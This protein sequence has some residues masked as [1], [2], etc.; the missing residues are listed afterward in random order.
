MIKIEG[1]K[2]DMI[3]KV[4]FC[5]PD[6]AKKILSSFFASDIKRKKTTEIRLRANMPASV[7]CGD[8]NIFDFGGNK[9]VF[10]EREISDIVSKLCE[11]SVHTYGNTVNEGYIA[12]PEGLRIGV[13]GRGISENSRLLSVREITS[14]CIRIPHIIK[15]AATEILPVIFQKRKIN[16]ALIFSLPGVGKT[17]I[18]RDIAARLSCAAKRRIAVVDSRGEIYIRE[19]FSN[20]ICDFLEGY[21]KGAG[22]EIATRTLSA[23]ALV[24]DEIGDGETEAILKAQ[25]TGVPLIATSHGDSFPSVIMRPGMKKLYDAGVFRY[26]IGV[27]RVPGTER[28]YFDIHDS[29]RAL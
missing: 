3:D 11:E 4:L 25:N 10:F 9:I 18:I 28:F 20:S 14:V 16:S 12:M 19:I 5:L 17:T 1:E 26:Y 6:G 21:P 8:E 24:C 2:M 7:T 13:C 23:E 22:I 29:R 15:G 27:S